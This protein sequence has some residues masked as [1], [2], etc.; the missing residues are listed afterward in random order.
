MA[1]RVLIASKK[2]KGGPSVF[3]NRIADALNK[4]DDIKVVRSTNEKF[5]LELSVVRHLFEHNKPKVLRV[6]G[7]YYTTNHAR[8][9]R[10]LSASIKASHTVVFQSY[11]SKKMCYSILGMKPKRRCVIRNGI[12]FGIVNNIKPR[13]DIVPGSFVASALWRD[14]KRPNS[15][16]KGFL[17]AS[18]SGHLYAIGERFDK[19][20]AGN[21]NIH[22]LGKMSFEESMAVM[23]ACE[24]MIHLCYID[25][26]PNTVVEGLA[27]G[28]NV[29][30][31][32]LG[33]T[34][35][36]VEDRGIVLDVDKGGRALQDPRKFDNLSPKIIANGIHQVMQL[37]KKP[38][39]E[40]LN[41][42]YV[43]EEYA[44]VIKRVLS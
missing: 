18:T 3:R 17:E 15:I 34:R 20:W 10:S 36:L 2:F 41:I 9:N 26:C 35:E 13:N 19:R 30:C 29:L 31:T 14:T 43:A 32:N 39:R 42:K 24:Y 40:E 8:S 5:D 12:D 28:L 7:C 38:C 25:S 1:I 22:V 16:A 11:F 4:R 37:P 6:D 27:C 23:K 44:K 33:G 21:K